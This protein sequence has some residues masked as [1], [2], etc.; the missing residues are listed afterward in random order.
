MAPPFQNRSKVSPVDEDQCSSGPSLFSSGLVPDAAGELPEL[1][2]QLLEFSVTCT[3]ASG[4]RRPATRQVH[5]QIQAAKS[6]QHA[7]ITLCDVCS[8]PIGGIF[9]RYDWGQI[10]DLPYAGILRAITKKLGGL[11]P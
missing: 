2:R 4:C 5:G 11:T 1:V 3:G 9:G 7:N 10:Y 8:P 6:R